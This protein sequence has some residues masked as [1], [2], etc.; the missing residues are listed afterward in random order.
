MRV[1]LVRR[2]FSETGGAEAYLLRL[3]EGLADSGYEPALVTSSEWPPQ[4]W[5]HGPIVRLP[6]GTPTA[7]AK[8]FLSVKKDFAVTLSLDRTPGCDVFRAGDGVH[9][10]WLRRRAAFEPRWKSLLRR[11]NPKHAALVIL[12]RE[13]FRQTAAIIA[14]SRM[15]AD[16]ITQCY[17]LSP[18]QISVV[19]N[20]IGPG[21]PLADRAAARRKLGV[22]D[23]S[24]CVLFAGT[25]WERK[26]LRF[27]VRAVDA[28]PFK[29]VLL[30]AG[31]GKSAAYA[32]RR[33]RF[34]GATRDLPLI[35]S[36][37]DA[38]LLPTIYDPFS[39]ACLEAS[40][41]GLPVVTTTANGFS[42]ILRPGIHGHVVEPGDV[43]GLVR[44][45]ETWRQADSQATARACR[46]LAAEYSLS[47]NVQKTIEIL[48]DAKSP[49]MGR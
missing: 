7:F 28:L 30:V 47:R 45:L 34:L 11:W 39:N 20:G 17:G 13:V 19:Y 31:R 43:T 25:G 29:A 40:A 10:A 46:A 16:E 15:V 48:R 21:F 12:E 42:E 32:G 24:F 23:D 4:A 1:G 5:R 18:K 26:G 14:N 36:A 9:S 6:G 37:A 2:G 41:A 3:A 8:A 35:F 49:C 27:A 38:F 44:S 22:E 33:T